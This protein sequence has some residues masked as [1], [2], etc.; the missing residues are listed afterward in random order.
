MTGPLGTV[1]LMVGMALLMVI[2]AGALL[3]AVWL[4]VSPI[5]ATTVYEP[6]LTGAVPPGVY[7]SVTA[8]R[9]APSTP[10]AEPLPAQA[11][12]S[13]DGNEQ[14]GDAVAA[15]LERRTA[16][17]AIVCLTTPEPFVAVGIWYED[18]TQTTDEEVVALLRENWEGLR[19]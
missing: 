12:V 3:P 15:L 2:V 16:T 8:P 7:V 14:V 19:P 1:T 13:A 17:D 18:F 11:V 4:A 9:S 10:V 5:E 6:A